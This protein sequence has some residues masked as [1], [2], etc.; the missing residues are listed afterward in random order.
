MFTS[1]EFKDFTRNNRIRH[2]TS[3]PYHPASNGLAERAVQT[4]KESMKKSSQGSIET[5]LFRFLLTYRT[6]PHTTTGTSP[7]E[8]LFNR[9]PRTKLDL[10]RPSVEARVEKKQQDQ[11]RAHDK[12]AKPRKFNLKDKVYVRNFTNGDSWTPGTIIK[13]ISP[14]S[15]II[16]LEDG[17]AVRRHIDHIRSRSTTQVTQAPVPDTEWSDL[18]TLDETPVDTDSPETTSPQS[19]AIETSSVRRSSRVSIPPTRYDPT[20]IHLICSF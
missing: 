15:S 16:E 1:A 10:L 11:K 8:L 5:R 3:A 2:V 20:T 9:R 14:L 4:F 13:L 7:A 17:R 6:T 18:P 19:P 12:S